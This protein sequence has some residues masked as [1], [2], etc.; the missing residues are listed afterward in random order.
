MYRNLSL[1]FPF[2]FLY[3]LVQNASYNTG[4]T[5]FSIKV[6]FLMTHFLIAITRRMVKATWFMANANV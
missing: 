1:E 3:E 6:T 2:G 5:V 4:F